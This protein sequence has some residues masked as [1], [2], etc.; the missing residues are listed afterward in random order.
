MPSD[1]VE[2]EVSICAWSAL[3]MRVAASLLA[4]RKTPVGFDLLLLKRNS[5][6]SFRDL[7][8]FPGG[9]LSTDDGQLLHLDK[10]RIAALRETF[11]ETGLLLL[12]LGS[13]LSKQ[14]SLDWRTTSSEDP[15]A[16][17]KL[18]NLRAHNHALPTLIFY[19][20]WTT[21]MGM[22]TRF[23]TRF[24][25]AQVTEALEWSH[26]QVDGTENVEMFWAS[27]K[28]AL[29]R[30]ERGEYQMLPPQIC[31]LRELAQSS[32]DALTIPPV[33][34]HIEPV[35]VNGKPHFSSL[36]FKL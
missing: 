1:L 7:V 25:L 29:A 5:R 30:A 27:P 34:E 26:L 36:R 32:W 3:T 31:A 16:F 21:P 23:N 18:L 4:C 10:H 11:E 22:P 9:A 33:V 12:K 13:N 19:A 6:N 20:H 2:V 17:A 24:Y 28:D 8:T 35:I 15:T 14:Q